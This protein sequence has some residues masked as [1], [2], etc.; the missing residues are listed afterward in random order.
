MQFVLEGK[1]LRFA[2]NVDAIQRAEKRPFSRMRRFLCVILD[3]PEHTEV[4]A[5]NDGVGPHPPIRRRPETMTIPCGAFQERAATGS[6]GKEKLPAAGNKKPVEMRR[7]NVS[8]GSPFLHR[9]GIGRD[10]ELEL[11]WRVPDFDGFDKYAV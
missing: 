7:F 9:R 5:M 4:K 3:M 1:R 8:V 6:P 10:R 11:S 2:V